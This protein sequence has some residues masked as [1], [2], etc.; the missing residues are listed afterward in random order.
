MTKQFFWAML[1]AAFT[2]HVFYVEPNAADDP[3]G[4]ASAV[5]MGFYS[6]CYRDDSACAT[7]G[8]LI[9]GAWRAGVVGVDVVRGNGRLVYV[10]HSSKPAPQSISKL[11]DQLSRPSQGACHAV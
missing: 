1:G 10:P 11:I 2:G 7:V 8:S 6:S 4:A 9:G 3:L 5:V